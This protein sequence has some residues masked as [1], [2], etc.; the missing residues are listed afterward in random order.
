MDVMKVMR[1]K[2]TLWIN[3]DELD[4]E[5]F[6]VIKEI[7]FGEGKVFDALSID[8]ESIPS[9]QHINWIIDGNIYQKLKALPAS[10]YISSHQFVY[11]ASTGSDCHRF[12]FH[13][14]FYRQYS[15]DDPQCA[16]FLEIDEMPNEL[17]RLTIE[18][19]MKC[20]KE[21]QFKQL[22]RTRVMSQEQRVTGFVTFHHSELDVNESMKWVFAMK[23]LNAEETEVDEEEEYLKDL[24]L[25]FEYDLME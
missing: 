14:R 10:R 9:V 15:V 6:S 13:F 11:D 22:L 4:R 12:T 19:D 21:R 3:H 1:V 8:K 18:I 16:I 17:K 23:V 5:E 2:N 25:I 24:Y 20:D 7:L